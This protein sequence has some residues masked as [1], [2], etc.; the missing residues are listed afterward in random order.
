M[1]RITE[2]HSFFYLICILQITEHIFVDLRL[3]STWAS[4]WKITHISPASYL[5]DVIFLISNSSE[6]ELEKTEKTQVNWWGFPF[7]AE[8]KRMVG[9]SLKLLFKMRIR[10]F[11]IPPVSVGEMF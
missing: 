4:S 3:V 6:Y 8:G 11:M 7:I 9:R 10:K 2:R 5:L 1:C